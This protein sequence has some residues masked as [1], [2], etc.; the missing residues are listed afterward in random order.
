M[1][2]SKKRGIQLGLSLLVAAAIFY[3][4]YR[5]VEKEAFVLALKE[6]RLFWLFASV[7]IGIVGYLVRAWRWKLLIATRENFSITTAPI[8]WALMLGYLVNLLLPR[9]GELA[10]CGAVNRVYPVPTG[11]LL[12]TVVLERT[13]D[14]AFMLLLVALALVS[15]GAVFSELLGM[16]VSF[17]SLNQFIEKYLVLGLVLG[18]GLLS[19]LYLAYRK[20]KNRQWMGKIRQFF[21]QFVSGLETVVQMKNQWAFWIASLCIWIIYFLMMYWIAFAMPATSSLSVG[22]ILMVLVMGSIGMVAPVQG[23]IGTFHALVAFIL[24][25]Y[26]ISE[27]QGKIFAL[28]VHASQMVTILLLG[29]MG[30]VYFL[31]VGKSNLRQEDHVN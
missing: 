31:V 17:S 10:R 1:K 12:G 23:G 14:M 30:L 8:F 13:I 5:D 4:L 22:S 2:Q 3:F 29:G 20:V 27:E 6:T 7:S 26:G 25:F 16:L 24:L 19:M 18:I 28:V 15:Q 11:K 9:A 21:R